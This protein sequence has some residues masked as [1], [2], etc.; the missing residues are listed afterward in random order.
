[1]KVRDGYTLENR[2]YSGPGM[3]FK[4]ED[5]GRLSKS[6]AVEKNAG[7]VGRPDPSRAGAAPP[8]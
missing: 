5:W 3:G 7:A 4:E 2:I 6:L 8:G 1:M